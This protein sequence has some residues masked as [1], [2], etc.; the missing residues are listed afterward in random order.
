MNSEEIFDSIHHIAINVADVAK[1]AQWYQTSFHCRVVFQE[2]TL[3]IVEF[4]NLKLYLLLPNQAPSH[5]AFERSDAHTFGELQ[6]QTD[7]SLA[8]FV[9]DPTGNV[10]QI[11]G[12]TVTKE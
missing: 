7:G 5:V 8:T 6:E 3:A 1:A 4:K 12:S 2:K 11:V 9:A 10:V